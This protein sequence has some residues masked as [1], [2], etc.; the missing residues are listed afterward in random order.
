MQRLS[1][2]VQALVLAA[3]L[4]MLAGCSEYLDRRD[5]NSLQSGNAVQTNKVTQIE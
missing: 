4:T 1:N 2:V 3:A 5:T